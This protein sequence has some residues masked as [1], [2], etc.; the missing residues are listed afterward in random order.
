MVFAL[1]LSWERGK[2]SWYVGHSVRDKGENAPV[3]RRAPKEEQS[4]LAGGKIKPAGTERQTDKS[5]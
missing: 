5:K 1:S 3:Q 4:S 2:T